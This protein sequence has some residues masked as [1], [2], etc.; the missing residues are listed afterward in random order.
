MSIP[1]AL[2]LLQWLHI[3]GGVIWFGSYVFLDFILWP[4]IWKLPASEGQRVK[5]TIFTRCALLYGIVG[6]LVVL[7]GFVRGVFFGPVQSVQFLLTTDY[8]RT[9]SVAFLLGI[10]LLVWG[11]FW[12]AHGAEP[13]WEGEKVSLRAVR[14]LKKGFL[15]EMCSFSVILTCMVL[16][17][18]GY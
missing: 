10:C 11:T 14:R 12:H 13:L 6:P 16:M 3:L 2:L 1:V 17:H 8:G 15:F 18:F 9:W 5:K 4:T 7:L